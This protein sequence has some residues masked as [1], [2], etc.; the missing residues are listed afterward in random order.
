MKEKKE[1][2]VLEKLVRISFLRKI[3]KTVQAKRTRYFIE[4]P[5]KQIEAYSVDYDKDYRITI[6]S[7]ENIEKRE[8][9]S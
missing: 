7:I 9:K 1:L 3:Y 5:R 4:V 6:E 2:V 8:E